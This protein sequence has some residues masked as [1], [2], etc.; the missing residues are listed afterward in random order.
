MKRIVYIIALSLILFGCSQKEKTKSTV[1]GKFSLL[2]DAEEFQAGDPIELKFRTTDIGPVHL[3]IEN[4]DGAIILSPKR[5]QETLIFS[6]PNFI[7]RRSGLCHWTL[8]QNET[9]LKEGTITIAPTRTDMVSVE[10]YLGPRSITAGNRDYTMHVI[11][12]TDQF[13]NPLPTGTEIISIHQFQDQIIKAPVKLKNLVGWHNI[14]SPLESGRI[15]VTASCRT[16]FSKE[17]TSLIYPENAVDFEI[18]TERNHDFADGNQVLLVSTGTI[19]DS[20]G[21]IVSDG[22][23]VNFMATNSLGMQLRSVGLTLNGVAK[24][25]FLHPYEQDTWELKAYVTGTAES[26]IEKIS[27]K[28]AIEDFE[29][30]FNENGGLVQISDIKSFMQQIVPD[31]IPIQMKMVD[32]NMKVIS[33]KQTTSRLGAGTFKVSTEFYNAGPYTI[34]VTMAGIRKTV[35]VNLK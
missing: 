34:E 19:K 26:N 27:F 25:R 5:T 12:P 29:L 30:D 8:V 9:Q 21:N 6:L 32:D 18:F 23:L 15:L 3:I 1:L 16:S 35:K 24:A 7:D 14:Y 4:S 2:T 10:S 11:A 20:Y 13:D 28:K 33:E 17:F 22:T 31:G